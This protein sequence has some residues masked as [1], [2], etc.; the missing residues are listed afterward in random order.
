MRGG[1]LL[2][3]V[4]MGA[5]AMLLLGGLLTAVAHHRS[6]SGQGG[7]PCAPLAGWQAVTVTARSAWG[8]ART[9][10]GYRTDGGGVVVPLGELA[11]PLLSGRGLYWDGERRTVSLLGPD[12]VLS[13][14]FPPGRESVERAVLNGAVIPLRAVLCGEQVYLP[15]EHLAAVLDLEVVWTGSDSL[16]LAPAEPRSR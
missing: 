6:A 10:T 1:W 7:A 15:V 14:H 5:A 11:E 2:R 4:M 12:D 13:V 16:R 8:G 9:G 3:A